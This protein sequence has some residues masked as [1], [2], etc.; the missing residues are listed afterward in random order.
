MMHQLEY[1]A[2][3][4]NQHSI[5]NIISWLKSKFGAP[6]RRWFYRGN[7]VYFLNE[8]DELMFLMFWGFK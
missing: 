3:N 1:A 7:T 6:G 5:I 8:A 2:V 4:I